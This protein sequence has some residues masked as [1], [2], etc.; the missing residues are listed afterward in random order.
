MRNAL[1]LIFYALNNE[2]VK[3]Q[4]IKSNVKQFSTIKTSFWCCFPDSKE[5][6]S[7]QN[8]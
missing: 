6:V 3:I 1:L 7:M 5:G 2:F 4:R 8:I